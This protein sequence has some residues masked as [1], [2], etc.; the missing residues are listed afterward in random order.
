MNQA[1]NPECQAGRVDIAVEQWYHY[2]I[3]DLRA[4]DIGTGPRLFDNGLEVIGD[5]AG[6]MEVWLVG[7]AAKDQIWEES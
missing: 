1:K 4:G 7:G 6:L 2:P 3:Q 5:N